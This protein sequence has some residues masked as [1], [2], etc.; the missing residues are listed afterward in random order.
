MIPA[1]IAIPFLLSSISKSI[2]SG[3]F[4]RQIYRLGFIPSSVASLSAVLILA[5]LWLISG[6]FVLGTCQTFTIPIA[7]GFILLAIAITLLQWWQQRR[8]SCGCYG[9]GLPI[10]PPI[11][12]LIDVLIFVGLY[13][14]PTSLCSHSALQPLAIFVLFGLIMGRFSL[15]KPLFDLSPTAIGRNWKH[16][17]F[18]SSNGIVAFISPE[19]EVC[20]EWIPVL[21]ALGKHHSVHILSFSP[22]PD[23]PPHIQYQEKT[24]R[25]ILTQI[26]QFPT[27]ISIQNGH[28]QKRWLGTPP[29]N[30]LEQINPSHYA[31]LS[32]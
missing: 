12:I 22:P 10:S 27:I 23:Y 3:F 17:S 26:E 29:E 15:Q 31:P 32:T 24:R 11:S 30:L 2:D 9:P 20:A 19:C 4:V 1:L 14:L 5:T 18:P 25:M 21:Y 16:T 6:S 7:Q 8:P 28:I 13:T